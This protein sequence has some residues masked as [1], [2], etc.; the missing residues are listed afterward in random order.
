LLEASSQ[1]AASPP[2]GPPTQADDVRARLEETQRKVQE[3]EATLLEHLQVLFQAQNYITTVEGSRGWAWLTRYYR[4]REFLFPRKS[5]RRFLLGTILK[6]MRLPVRIARRVLRPRPAPSVQARYQA[7]IQE[8]E[9]AAEEIDEQ[10]RHVFPWAPCVSMLAAV[11][12]AQPSLLEAMLDSVFAQTYANWEL[13]LAVPAGEPPDILKLLE[14]ARQK[15]PGVRVRVLAEDWD[16]AGI[17]NSAL[18]EASGEY[19]AILNQHDTLAPFALHE[20]ANTLN[21]QPDADL[22]YSDEDHLTG[23][24]ERSQPHFKPDWSPDTFRSHNYIGNLAVMRRSLVDE[25]GRFRTGFAEPGHYDLLLRA[26]ERARRIVHIPK[27]LY[28]TRAP[29]CPKKGT[30]PLALPRAPS[31]CKGRG[32]SEKGTGLLDSRGQSLFPATNPRVLSPFRTADEVGKKALAEHLE[33]L[34]IAAEVR[35]GRRPGTYRV[36]YPLKE[37]PLVSLVIPNKD[38]VRALRRCIKSI[39]RSSYGNYE[40]LIIENHSSLARTFA[41][42][43][44]LAKRPNVRVLT[45]TRPFNYAAVNNFAA[46][47]ARGDV[48][49][50]LNNDTEVINRDWLECLL[51]HALRPEVGAAGAML[52]YPDGTVQHAGAIVGLD[53][54]VHYQR[55]APCTSSGYCNRLVTVQNL[56]AVTGACLMTRK[57]VFEQVGGFDETFALTFN[58]LDLCLKIRQRGYLIIWTPYAELYHHELLTRGRTDSAAKLAHCYYEHLL[59]KSK[60]RN[61]LDKTDCYYNPNLATDR[62]D[63]SPRCADGRGALPADFIQASSLPGCPARP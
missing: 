22:V 38:L 42:Y 8:N 45:W 13:C 36:V 14:K 1:E 15:Q 3:L 62:E 21:A 58:D 43:D 53:R 4:L 19:I 23:S 24:G 34:A 32:L 6:P 33:R 55:L 25:V 17:Y 27:V 16:L 35:D 59:F 56:S 40:I 60:W 52:Y 49:L 47:Q 2:S 54:G 26:S 5:I 31:G 28:H 29:V 12:Q 51:E 61:V 50:F 10:G 44:E 57:S 20:I 37:R 39:E 46:G 41:Y 63:C 11:R 18:A 9:P 30:A 48:L 7:W